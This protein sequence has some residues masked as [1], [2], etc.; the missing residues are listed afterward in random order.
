MPMEKASPE[1]S[2]SRKHNQDHKHTHGF[3]RRL[4]VPS[5]PPIECEMLR[6]LYSSHPKCFRFLVMHKG[7]AGDESWE[8]DDEPPPL[9]TSVVFVK[10]IGAHTESPPIRER[11]FLWRGSTLV[12]TAAPLRFEQ[13]GLVGTP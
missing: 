9:R 11:R 10:A 13:S 2:R 6:R 3:P 4:G 7:H 1:P 8:G 5:L 12:Q